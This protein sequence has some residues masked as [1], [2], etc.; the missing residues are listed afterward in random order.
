MQVVLT[1]VT[2]HASVTHKCDHT[3]KCDLQVAT[4]LPHVDQGNQAEADA[5]QDQDD[6]LGLVHFVGAVDDEQH[7]A[8]HGLGQ[9]GDDA[10]LIVGLHEGRGGGGVML[11]C[12]HIVHSGRSCSSRLL[13]LTARATP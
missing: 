10:G 2:R 4:G 8:V 13:L 12:V 9:A 1:S 6:D 3:C 5:L 7:H 11:L